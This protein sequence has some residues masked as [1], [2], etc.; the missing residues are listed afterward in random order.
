M[1]QAERIREYY[2][3]TL[4]PHMMKWLRSLVQQIVM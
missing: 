2:E 3:S 1:T 4:L